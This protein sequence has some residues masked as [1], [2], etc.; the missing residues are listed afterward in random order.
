MKPLCETLYKSGHASNLKESS[1]KHGTSHK[2]TRYPHLRD[3]TIMSV[4]GS[5]DAS[6]WGTL[7]HFFDG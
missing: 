4:L 3:N 6:V 2:C 1:R 5:Q 7:R